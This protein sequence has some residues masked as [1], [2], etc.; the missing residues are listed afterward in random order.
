LSAGALQ[1]ADELSWHAKARHIASIYDDVIANDA[2]PVTDS[3]IGARY[4]GAATSVEQN[5]TIPN[6]T[7]RRS[8][9]SEDKGSF[10][11]RVR[12]PP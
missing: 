11:Y 1:R 9:H 6:K 2:R 12:D 3:P 8:L 7:R 5:C 4:A 10:R